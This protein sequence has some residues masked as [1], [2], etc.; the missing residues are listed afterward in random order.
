MTLA[1]TAELLDELRRHIIQARLIARGL[2]IALP[3]TAT[4]DDALEEVEFLQAVTRVE[5]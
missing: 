2:P 3:L 4:L 1:D 5:R